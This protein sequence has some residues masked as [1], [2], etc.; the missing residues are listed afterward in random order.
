MRLLFLTLVLGIIVQRKGEKGAKGEKRCEKGKKVRK[1]K[2]GAKREKRCER[3]K[4][5]LIRV[6]VSKYFV[7]K[8]GHAM[9]L[10]PATKTRKVTCGLSK[11]RPY[12]LELS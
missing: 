3:G 4:N 9:K 5:A 7:L 8:P 2:K 11:T 1:R 12:K 6:R 10:R